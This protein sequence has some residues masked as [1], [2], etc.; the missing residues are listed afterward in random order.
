MADTTPLH[1]Y[2]RYI[3]SAAD[4]LAQFIEMDVPTVIITHQADI[5][6]RRIDRV[7]QLAMEREPQDDS[8][9]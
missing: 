1:K 5:L 3:R 8:T 2:P 7:I 4:F 6:R 9:I